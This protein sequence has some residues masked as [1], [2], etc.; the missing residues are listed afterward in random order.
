MNIAQLSDNL[1]I[2]LPINT[3]HHFRTYLGILIFSLEMLS[4][5]QTSDDRHLVNARN[6][7]YR[8]RTWME[9]LI[10]L[11]EFDLGVYATMSEQLD[12]EAS[13]SL[14]IQEVLSI[15]HD[16]K[17]QI[18]LQIDYGIVVSAPAHSFTQAVRHL[19][20]NAC[21][22]SPIGGLIRVHLQANGLTGSVLTIQ[23]QGPGIPKEMRKVVFDRFFQ[24]Q[25]YDE[26]PENHGM[27]LGLSMAQSFAKSQA[28]DVQ[29]LESDSGCQVQM[30]L[31]NFPFSSP[32]PA[33]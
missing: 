9:T 29:I 17:L 3:S 28:G 26:L 18:D 8:I 7:A 31:R 14:P 30:T 32:H 13:F 2:S 1:S 20:D 15:W 19:M 25:G 24:S 6:S 23:D 12:L 21:K 5:K 33:S 10:W 4:K 16:K 22:F 11:N 27:G